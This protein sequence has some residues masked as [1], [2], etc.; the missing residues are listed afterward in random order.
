MEEARLAME[1]MVFK[2]NLQ[3]ESLHNVKNQV[4]SANLVLKEKQNE[5]LTIEKN[6]NKLGEIVNDY[7]NQKE[8]LKKECDTKE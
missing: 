7:Q 2:V 3:E 1:E 6:L 8:Q 4:E 5:I